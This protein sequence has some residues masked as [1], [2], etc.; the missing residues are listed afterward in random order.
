MDTALSHTGNTHTVK[1]ALAGMI[2]PFEVQPSNLLQELEVPT[3]TGKSI[4][5]YLEVYTVIFSSILALVL[6]S[7][8]FFF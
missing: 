7:E 2:S 4:S 3:H 6:I 8:S 1:E 5:Y